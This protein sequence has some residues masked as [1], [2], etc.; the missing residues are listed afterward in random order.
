MGSQ[1]V[2]HN[3]AT[4]TITSLKIFIP[5]LI[6]YIVNKWL[7]GTIDISNYNL[8][9]LPYHFSFTFWQNL[10]L[11]TYINTFRIAISLWLTFINVKCLFLVIFLILELTLL[12]I[13]ALHF[14]WWVFFVYHSS[15]S[16]ES[17]SVFTINLCL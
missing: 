12:L 17:V 15:F 14:S 4:N 1:R 13:Q 3:W 2:G 7:R 11:Y 5:L 6:C 10:K 9:L 16:F 8:S